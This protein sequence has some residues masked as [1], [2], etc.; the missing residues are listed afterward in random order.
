MQGPTSC[1]TALESPPACDAPRARPTPWHASRAASP[2]HALHVRTH[3]K[4]PEAQTGRE[5]G[6]PPQATK[7]EPQE[8][9]IAPPDTCSPREARPDTPSS[10][11]PSLGVHRPRR[12]DIPRGARGSR[13]LLRCRCSLLGPP[14]P[15]LRRGSSENVTARRRWSAA[16]PQ[17]Q[18]AAPAPA[19]ATSEAV[20]SVRLNRELSAMKISMATVRAIAGHTTGHCRDLGS[21]SGHGWPAGV[22]TDSPAPWR[23]K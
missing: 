7:R 14:A 21:S 2:P 20:A 16:P 6:T 22:Q 23:P 15:C 3:D 5:A 13:E 12:R 19:L 10:R 4:A 11:T 9:R 18:P 1:H 8:E 17:P